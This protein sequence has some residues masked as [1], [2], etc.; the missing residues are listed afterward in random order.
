MFDLRNQ[1]SCTFSIIRMCA[2]SVDSYNTVEIGL[3]IDDFLVESHT[4]LSIST[5]TTQC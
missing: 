4:V 3:L 2:N 1:H 5:Q